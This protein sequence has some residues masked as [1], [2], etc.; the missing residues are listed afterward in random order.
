MSAPTPL[1]I[2]VP[3]YND[4]A[5]IEQGLAALQPLRQRGHELLVVDGGSRDGGVTLA[6]RHADRVLLSGTG[7]VL[8][9]NSGSEYA[10]HDV[11]LFLP[12]GTLLPAE[13]DALIAAALQPAAAQW[14]GFRLRFAAGGLAAMAAAFVINR[15]ATSN[16]TVIAEQ[17]VFA[18]RPFFERVRGFDTTTPATLCERLRL[19]APPV[20]LPQAVTSLTADVRRLL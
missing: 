8:Q 12:L 7:P 10:S 16:G 5:F 19:A 9:M 6:R 14:G 3:V 13:T 17:C 20:L 1:S 18:K 2:I 4:A 15:R 11:L